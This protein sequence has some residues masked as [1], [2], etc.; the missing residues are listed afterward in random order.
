LVGLDGSTYSTAA[1]DL[2]I[3]WARE[4]DALLSGLGIID[5]PTIRRPEP[6]PLGAGAF[7][8]QRDE[9][10]VADARR[11]VDLFLEHF[12]SRCAEAGVTCRLLKSIGPPREQILTEAQR[13]DVILLGKQ[14]Y[15]HF[16]T[17]EG[18]DETLRDVLKNT[19]RPV[20][21]V[22]ES[23]ADG[24][25][26]VIAYD[27]SLQAARALQ[28]FQLLKPHG[29]QPVHIV[30]VHADTSEAERRAGCAAE[31]LGLHGIEAERHAL[32]TSS[33]PE[34]A[35]VEEVHRLGAGLVVMG[36]YGKPAVRE[37]F[38]GSVTR[39]MLREKSAPLFLYH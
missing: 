13:C 27:G 7:K 32:A 31:F 20:V 23:L 29:Q 19:P 35:L 33:R 8:V 2:G 3:R 34:L 25:S 26:T 10:L 39:A 9:A 4:F 18:P 24:A 11:Q 6:V 36:A 17:Q 16:E 1:V 14:T 28:L 38:F 22:P 15:Y 5:E 37:F 30:A 21:T 12:T